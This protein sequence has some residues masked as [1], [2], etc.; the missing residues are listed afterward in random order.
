VAPK[1]APQSRPQSSASSTPI[2]GYQIN[3]ARTASLGQHRRRAAARR[4]PHESRPSTCS[5]S[6]TSVPMIAPTPPEP[7]VGEVVD[8]ALSVLVSGVGRDALPLG[9]RRGA[10]PVA[11]NLIGHGASSIRRWS[12]ARSSTGVCPLSVEPPSPAVGGSSSGQ[13]WPGPG[14]IT[15]AIFRRLVD[16]FRPEHDRAARPRAVRAGGRQI[17]SAWCSPLAW[18]EYGVHLVDLT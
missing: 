5:T 4:R 16:H 9:F 6:L 15:T 12:P 10:G 1:T 7:L 3:I 17:C 11:G 18:A 13:P 8:G 14:A 2:R